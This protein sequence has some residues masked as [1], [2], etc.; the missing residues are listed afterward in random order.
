MPGVGEQHKDSSNDNPFDEIKPHVSEYTAAEIAKLSSRLEK[1]LGPEYIS[2]R[3][4]AG[5][6]KFHYLAAGMI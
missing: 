6:G 5:G 3:P 2:T 1:Q 4:G